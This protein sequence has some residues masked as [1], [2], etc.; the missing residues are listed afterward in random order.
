LK[1]LRAYDERNWKIWTQVYSS[2]RRASKA[3]AE[4]R[5]TFQ[6]WLSILSKQKFLCNICKIKTPLTI[7][8]II[9]LSKGG[10]NWPTN[11]QALCNPCNG[12][13]GDDIPE[14]EAVAA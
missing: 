3:G 5:L 11:I 6:D 14:Q 2:N 9:P 7:D 12:R 13:K 8:H 1:Y 10:S 4:G